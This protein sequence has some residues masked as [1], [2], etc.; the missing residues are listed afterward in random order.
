VKDAIEAVRSG[1][2]DPADVITH[3]YPLEKLDEALNATRDRPGDFV[4]AIVTP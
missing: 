1:L 4:K 3:R 2:I